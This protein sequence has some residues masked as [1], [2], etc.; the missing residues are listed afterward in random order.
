MMQGT[1]RNMTHIVEKISNPHGGRG[2][3]MEMAILFGQISSSTGKSKTI[4]ND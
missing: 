2:V 1:P 4:W 3:T